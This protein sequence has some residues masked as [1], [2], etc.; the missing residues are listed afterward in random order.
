MARN[1]KSRGRKR[2][3]SNAGTWLAILGAFGVLGILIGAGLY[4]A[5][6]T[7]KEIA[8]NQDDLCPKSGACHCGHFTGYN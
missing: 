2:K 5:V 4:L 3:S 8:L 6:N 1:R 7:E